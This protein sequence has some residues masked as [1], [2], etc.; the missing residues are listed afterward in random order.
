MSDKMEPFELIS[1]SKLYTA[2][3]ASI[4]NNENATTFLLG[5]DLYS[6]FTIHVDNGDI[7]IPG[8]RLIIGTASAVLEAMVYGVGSLPA[9]KIMTVKEFAAK[10]FIEVLYLRL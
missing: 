10:D 6:D 5:N 2:S 9:P 7:T 3:R 4:I 1:D 8:H